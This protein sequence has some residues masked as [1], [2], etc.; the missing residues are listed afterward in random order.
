M[1]PTKLVS[2]ISQGV[3]APVNQQ[4]Y[5]SP[6]EQVQGRFNSIGNPGPRSPFGQ[7]ATFLRQTPKDFEISYKPNPAL[8]VFNA[9]IEEYRN[10]ANR[11][12]DHIGR[13]N[14][15]W[16]EMLNYVTQW[17]NPITKRES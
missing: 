4:S 15:R 12:V 2:G 8:K 3:G 5:N 17:Q 11:A 9:T 16:P 10:W 14:F 13:N 7:A 6:P 1:P